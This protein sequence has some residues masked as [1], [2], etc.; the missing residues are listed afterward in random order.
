[1]KDFFDLAI[2]CRTF[3]FSGPVLKDAITATFQRRK[4][5]IPAELPIALT[6][7]FA[8]DSAKRKQWKAF[9]TRNGLEEKVGELGQVIDDLVLFLGPPMLAAANGNAIPERWEPGGPWR[10]A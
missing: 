1:M 8:N 2:L 6:K 7:S 10:M 9:V 4:T 3:A 5:A